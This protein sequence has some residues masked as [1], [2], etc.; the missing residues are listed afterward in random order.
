M[1]IDKGLDTTNTEAEI[2]K[3]MAETSKL[4][5]EPARMI[6]ERGWCPMIIIAAALSS[7][8]AIENWSSANKGACR[9][10]GIVYEIRSP[11]T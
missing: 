4:S 8:A 9:K 1:Q 2:A 7:G 10:A 6:R 3:L 11:D 5:S